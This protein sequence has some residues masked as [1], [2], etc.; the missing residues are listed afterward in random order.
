MNN[1]WTHEYPKQDGVYLS[2]FDEWEDD[3]EAD[4]ED[5]GE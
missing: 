4:A 5:D 2:A 1:N 3:E